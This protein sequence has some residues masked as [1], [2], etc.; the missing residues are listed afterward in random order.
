MK[1]IFLFLF[2]LSVFGVFSEESL[3]TKE[4]T[5]V[6]PLASKPNIDRGFVDIPVIDTTIISKAGGFEIEFE[7]SN[8]EVVGTVYVYFRTGNGFIYY[9][10]EPDRHSSSTFHFDF[11]RSRESYTEGVPGP[12]NKA[13]MIRFCVYSRRHVQPVDA[14]ITLKTFSPVFS[15]LILLTA[16]AE[17]NKQIHSLQKCMNQAGVPT[18]IVV[19]DKMT[20]RH[21]SGMKSVVLP[22][23]TL[24]LP[25]VFTLLK[26]FARNGGIIIPFEQVSKE[27]EE[28]FSF[29]GQTDLSIYHRRLI[30][31]WQAL[32][33]V[34]DMYKQT[35][36]QKEK[37]HK[38]LF[39]K[40]IDYGF[41]LNPSFFISNSSND[42]PIDCSRYKELSDT[43]TELYHRA[44]RDYCDTIA[45]GKPEFRAWFEHSGLGVYPGDWDRTMQEISEAG[46]NA[47]VANFLWGAGGHYAS[48]VIQ[49]TAVFD[50]YGDQVEQALKAAKKRN[51][52]LH[53]WQ[54]CYQLAGNYT[55]WWYI[56]QL[57]KEKR[58][59]IDF[60]GNQAYWLCPSNPDN[61]TLECAALCE[62]VRKYPDLN[63]IHLD[64]IRYSAD[65]CYCGGCKERFISDTGLI[66][67]NWPM[68]VGHGGIYRKLFEGWRC[69][70][71]T[72]LVALVHGEA[73]RIRPDIKISASVSSNYPS[74]KKTMGQDWMKW[75]DYG[76][77]DF[78]C[79]MI[80]TVNSD[81]F[82]TAVKLQSEMIKNKIPVYPAIGATAID[83]PLP[84]DRVASQLKITQEYNLPGFIIFALTQESIKTIPSVINFNDYPQ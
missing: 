79:P 1:Q 57:E 45:I 77:L 73:K 13:D 48:D 6:M 21:L 49:R 4:L 44:I 41:D 43:L 82:E 71:I 61:I 64:Y 32:T 46:Y 72:R 25:H 26:K 81:N 8:P 2:L 15:S 35:K 7:C 51:I 18:G 69:E 17:V 63:G 23:D 24:L 54:V 80:Y 27:R 70:Q 78:I 58:L 28:L 33:N 52:E 38:S 42:R 20:D 10:H 55:P 9:T 68:D 83:L 76:Y 53:A 29:F 40:L 14:T 16:N 74:C 11:H 65:H 12:L 59:Q 60:N 34:G 36:K 62:L 30:K 3:I 56:V 66:G 19:Q 84:L 22:P 67:I 5:F 50:K 39:G 37:L 47:V 75:I 31:D